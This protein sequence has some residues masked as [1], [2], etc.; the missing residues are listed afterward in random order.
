MYS[1]PWSLRGVNCSDCRGPSRR[2]LSISAALAVS[3]RSRRP[4]PPRRHLHPH[5][6][7]KG[8]GS[9]RQRGS[10][11]MNQMELRVALTGSG[12]HGRR[13]VN[14]DSRGC[15]HLAQQATGSDPDFKDSLAMPR[16]LKKRRFDTSKADSASPGS[17]GLVVSRRDPI[18]IVG[19]RVGRRVGRVGWIPI[20]K[21]RSHRARSSL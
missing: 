4:E 14:A 18:I 12:Q 19:R 15:G 13:D 2:S 3:L 16:C 20:T 17:V 5:D 21:G 1:T 9:K 7:I 11:G 8:I 6:R 10:I